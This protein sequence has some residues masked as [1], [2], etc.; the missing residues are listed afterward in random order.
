M[1]CLRNSSGSHVIAKNP[2]SSR[3][4]E[5]SITHAPGM[6]DGMNCIQSRNTWSRVTPFKALRVSTSSGNRLTMAW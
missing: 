3:I 2:R 6:R 1:P 5:M 4:G